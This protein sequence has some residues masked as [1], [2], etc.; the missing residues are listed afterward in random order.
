MTCTARS[1]SPDE[2]ALQPAS[3][4]PSRLLLPA[5]A[6]W[7]LFFLLPLLLMVAISLAERGPYGGV[8]WRFTLTNYRNVFDPLYLNILLRSLLL[9][10]ATTASCLLAAFPMAYYIARQPPR[11][12]AVWL[13]LIMVPFWTNFLVR[14]YA[15]MF[16][17]R[18]QGLLQTVAAGLGWDPSGLDL[19][20]TDT[21]VLIGLVYGYLPFMIL[22]LYAAIERI[23]PALVEA[24][25]DLYATRWQ[26]FRRVLLPLA[27]PGIVAG[28][29]LVF[30]PSLGAFLTPD[31]LGGAKSM[32]VGNLIQHEFL[33]VR[34]WPFGS[35]L[36]LVVMALVLA[37]VV[38]YLKAEGIDGA[39]QEGGRKG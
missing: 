35:A 29:L 11:R 8:V 3:G 23:P 4:R 26:V 25:W 24:A 14:T 5:L 9:A 37:G 36:S 7:G 27:R 33:V 18:S 30:I 28:C 39:R 13:L 21:A 2:A 15:W 20:Y 17:L 12:Q 6:W 1:S 31:I 38:G 34:D 19:L 32:M 16:I 10:G 22:P